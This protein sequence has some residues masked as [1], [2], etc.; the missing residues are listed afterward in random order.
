MEQG[1]QFSGRFHRF[2]GKLHW[3][4]PE[5]LENDRHYIGEGA[6]GSKDVTDEEGK[7]FNEHMRALTDMNHRRLVGDE[8]LESQKADGYNIKVEDLHHSA[9]A[10][11]YE[12]I[13]ANGIRPKITDK[14]GTD[15]YHKRRFGVFMAN[16]YI[17]GEANTR[18]DVY[19]IHV[20][21]SELR[22]DPYTPGGGNL[23][24]ERTV[25]PE[26]LEHIGH[27]GNTG[28]FYEVHPGRGDSCATCDKQEAD[29]KEWWESQKAKESETLA[30]P[31]RITQDHYADIDENGKWVQTDKVAPSHSVHYASGRIETHFDEDHAKEKCPELSKNPNAEIA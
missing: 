28:S 15:N 5:E 26:E 10:S 11:R 1:Q 24:I 9:P 18:A 16:G 7:E 31:V 14:V 30:N 22:I 29:R 17:S 19:R 21:H 8:S 2:N 20:P 23:L 12:E 4:T 13:M 25:R 27:V 6:K 3:F